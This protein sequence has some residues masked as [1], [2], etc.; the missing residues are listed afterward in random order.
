MWP[1]GRWFRRA[2]F[3]F[4]SF[5]WSNAC[6]RGAS[7]LTRS[8]AG[9]IYDSLLK[10]VVWQILTNEL[11]VLPES[12]KKKNLIIGV[13]K[14]QIRR[15]NWLSSSNSDSEFSNSILR[16]C[17]RTAMHGQTYTSIKYL[18]I[19]PILDNLLSC[20]LDRIDYMHRKNAFTDP[21]NRVHRHSDNGF[22]VCARTAVTWGCRC[23]RSWPLIIPYG[24][25]H[26]CSSWAS[27]SWM[28]GCSYDTY[29][30]IAHTHSHLENDLGLAHFP[31][32]PC[33][34]LPL[35][36][37]LFSL[38]QTRCCRCKTGITHD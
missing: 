20:Y 16:S 38:R 31:S 24:T 11:I 12:W 9:V 23:W 25:S 8:T 6:C 34:L 35:F 32:S 10:F 29:I 4:F 26:M 15:F 30:A 37:M 21:Y 14:R 2:F 27:S 5:H 28:C 19:A 18:Y 36:P 17:S 1:S 7:R 33:S 22:A 3:F 13:D